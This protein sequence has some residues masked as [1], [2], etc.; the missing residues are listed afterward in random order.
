MNSWE[1]T[2]SL[3]SVSGQN[4]NL[5]NA[6]K[7]FWKLIDV[8]SGLV[9]A[10]CFSESAAIDGLDGAEQQSIDDEP[11]LVVVKRWDVEQWDME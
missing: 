5:F 10:G 3:I 4:R 1:E 8:A 6:W 2:R 11:G 7:F 9:V